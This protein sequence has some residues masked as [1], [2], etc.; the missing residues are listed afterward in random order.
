MYVYQPPSKVVNCHGTTQEYDV[1]TESKLP[2]INYTSVV[3]PAVQCMY[4]RTN[5]C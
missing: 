5:E 3:T 2:S 1:L 4:T